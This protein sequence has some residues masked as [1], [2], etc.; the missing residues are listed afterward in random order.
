MEDKRDF[1]DKLKR[2]R[3]GPA[4]MLQKD[5][6]VILA[7]TGINKDSRVL[8]AGAGSGVLTAN[9]ARFVKRVYS[10]DQSK[11][12]LDIAKENCKRLGLTN[13]TFKNKDVYE[14]IKEKN[15]DL[16]TLDLREPWRAFSN[17]HNA[18]KENGYCV[19]FTPHI[20]QV[21]KIL[22]ISEGLFKIIKTVEDIEREWIVEKVR[23]RPE[24]KIIGHTAFI[25]ILRKV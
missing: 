5:V 12:F 21:S 6:G 10:Y 18:L 2:I 7:N 17:A 1:L 24:N 25:T 23:L 15:L 13:I 16:V 9:L 14:E 22:E 8:D 20:T 4:I 3:R 11:E 19:C